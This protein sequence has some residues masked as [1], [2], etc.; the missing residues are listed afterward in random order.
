M[1]M[2][3]QTKI[4][5][6]CRYL[7]DESLLEL[8]QQKEM[9]E[10]YQRV[11]S[12]LESGQVDRKLEADLD[13]LNS[14]VLDSTG[15]SLYSTTRNYSLL[16]GTSRSTGAQWWSCPQE[17]CAGR[18]RVKAGQAAPICSISGEPLAQKPLTR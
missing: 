15:Y 4:S 12:M 16:P 17:R 5:G 10:L 2:D 18:G 9:E 7:E 13:T 8:V 11:R 3:V 14:M 6:F 1:G